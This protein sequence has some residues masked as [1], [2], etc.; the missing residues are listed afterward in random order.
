MIH[1]GKKTFGGEGP[2][3]LLAG[4]YGSVGLGFAPL[5]IREAPFLATVAIY[6]GFAAVLIAFFVYL[7][8][9]RVLVTSTEV[10]VRDWGGQRVIPRGQI[11]EVVHIADFE[12]F[13]SPKGY[14]ALLDLNGAPL[15][16]SAT[17]PWTPATLE[18]LGDAGRTRSLIGAMNY[19]Q[20]HARW[21]RML[22]WP[23]AH[24]R[25]ALWAGM[26][27]LVVV[28]GALIALVVILTT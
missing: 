14:V 23:L 27:G 8:R 16:R 9:H 17:H 3:W 12:A 26:L 10:R 25:F 21:P 11:G 19:Q 24:S 7:S 6:L 15:W 22:P 20:V 4:V 13:A 28:V 2:G 18:A 5:L 1:E